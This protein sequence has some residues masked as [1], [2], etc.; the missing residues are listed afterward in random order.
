MDLSERKLD[1][2]QVMMPERGKLRQANRLYAWL[3]TL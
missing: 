3:R 2:G 1:I